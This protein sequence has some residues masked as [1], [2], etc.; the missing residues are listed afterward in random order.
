[1]LSDCLEEIE[2]LSLAKV[3]NMTTTNSEI[4]PVCTFAQEEQI[5]MFIDKLEN[6]FN[7]NEVNNYDIFILKFFSVLIKLNIFF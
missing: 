6:I 3:K 4:K 7:S 2:Q 5:Q 1:M